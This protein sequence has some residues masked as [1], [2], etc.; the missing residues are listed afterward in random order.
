[1]KSFIQN[2]P[3][4]VKQDVEHDF[5][6]L[7][8]KSN[9][10][11][12]SITKMDMS[13]NVLRNYF[14]GSN[15]TNGLNHLHNSYGIEP[16]ACFSQ[17]VR[18]STMN[19]DVAIQDLRVGDLVKTYLDGYK[20][21]TKIGYRHFENCS[22]LDSSHKL[23]V[24]KSN[25]NFIVTGN[26]PVLVD[27]LTVEQKNKMSNLKWPQIH[28]DGKWMLCSFFHPDF[29]PLPKNGHQTIWDFVLESDGDETKSYGVYA[30]GILTKNME[31]YVFDKFT[32]FV[33]VA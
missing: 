25:P 18:I 17:G 16:N 11:T 2:V 9:Q 13:G 31:E 15:N 19:G 21:I 20:A 3:M 27:E 1:M 26:H 14:I 10:H 29:E 28:L 12:Y 23:F 32:R 30:E 5:Y 7:H 22:K 6:F 4:H 24:M 8:E 33:S